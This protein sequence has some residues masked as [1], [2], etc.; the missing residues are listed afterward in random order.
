MSIACERCSAPNPNG[1]RFFNQC[2]ALLF[3]EP[4]PEPSAIAVP[5]PGPACRECQFVNVA[6]AR[7]CNQC[8]APLNSAAAPLPV[9]QAS[10]PATPPE[11]SRHH[12]PVTPRNGSPSFA[13]PASI[14]GL[15]MVV[16]VIGF[17][18]WTCYGYW[19]TS[20]GAN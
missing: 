1:G 3:P 7:F 4:K 19:F 6:S 13:N 2:S 11:S 5:P 16:A 18:I 14:I 9:A 17:T 8:G 10:Q 12:Y 15:L 20:A